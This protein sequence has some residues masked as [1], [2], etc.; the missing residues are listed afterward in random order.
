MVDFRGVL[1]LY[2]NSL[3][4]DFFNLISRFTFLKSF[5]SIIFTDAPESIWNLIFAFFICS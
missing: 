1:E 4:L 5:S 2:E 3:T